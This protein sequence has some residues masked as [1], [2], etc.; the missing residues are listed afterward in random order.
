MNESTRCQLCGAQENTIVQNTRVVMHARPINLV[1]CCCCGLLY[2]NHRPKEDELSDVYREDYFIKWYSSEKK[3]RFAKQYFREL[4]RKNRIVAAEGSNI[5]DVGC[6][7]GFFMEVGQ[8]WHCNV[9]GVELS[10]F[11]SRY[12]T[13]KLHL[14]VY[15]GTLETA[16]YHDDYFDV[17]TAFDVLEHLGELSS[18]MASMRK[19]LKKEGRL[20]VLV[21]NYESPVFQLDRNIRRL[22]KEPLPNVPEHLTYFTMDS[23][24]RMLEKSGFHVT[25]M[26]TTKANDDG[27]FLRLR[28]SLMAVLRSCLNAMSYHVGRLSNRREAILAVSE[29]AM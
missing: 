25:S 27:D 5:L 4:F 22:K 28:G 15:N 10:T 11:A 29:K 9:K 14:D 8:E 21:P 1:R 17:I 2:L 6:G 23:L 3:R 12:C 7:M 20:I 19:V 24:H 13:E 18:S 26:L 16:D